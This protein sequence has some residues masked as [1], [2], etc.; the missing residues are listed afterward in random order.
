MRKRMAYKLGFMV[1]DYFAKQEDVMCR[2]LQFR[3]ISGS[4]VIEEK[5]FIF[6]FL[7]LYGSWR[8]G[9]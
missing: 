9:D 7:G 5:E 2:K 3:S 4:Y 1:L 8:D 6:F